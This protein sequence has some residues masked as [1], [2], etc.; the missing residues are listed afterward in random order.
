LL[1]VLQEGGDATKVLVENLTQVGLYMDVA[2]SLS[3]GDVPISEA[4]GAAGEAGSVAITGEI[5]KDLG[6]GGS[7]R[8]KA[9]KFVVETVAGEL[10]QQGTEKIDE[11]ANKEI[12]QKP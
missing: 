6:S 11:L 5:Q 3:Q 8:A 9:V 7:L 4:A 2:E 12:E 1:L 10:V